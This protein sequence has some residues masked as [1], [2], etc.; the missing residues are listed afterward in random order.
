VFIDTAESLVGDHVPPTPQER[1][2]ELTVLAVKNCLAA[3]LTGVHNMGG[4]PSAISMF[5][6]LINEGRFPFRV[7]FNLSSRLSN[8]DELLAQGVQ[9]Y[10]DNRLI[11]RSV[12][13]FADGALGSRG[14]ALIEPYSD[15]PEST[16]L[17]I[18]PT[19][20]LADMAKRA[21]AAGFQ[22][23]THA[24][25]DNGNRIA[26]DAFEIALQAVPVEDHRLRV[27][28]AQ[29]LAPED[30]PRFKELGVLP[31]MQPTHCTSD[32]PWALDRLG[33]ER[34]KGAYAWRS[35]ID[36]GVIIPCGSDFPVEL[37]YPMHGIYSAV[38][39]RHQDGTPA[40]GYFPEQRM[41]REEAL[42]GFTIWAAY[43]GFT[44]DWLGS[45]EPGKRADLIVLDRDIMKVEVEK[46]P[47][48]KVLLTV[49]DGEIV[50]EAG[51]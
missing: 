51:N 44:E 8:L 36:T 17:I 31:S 37:I 35:L 3:G 2:K 11:V 39:R 49:F 12:K 22:V 20:E 33:A 1:L 4:G 7:Y 50:Y 5:K 21:L 18:T 32:F 43:A 13:C 27:E 16:G 9:Y 15:R 19:D 25:G 47:D 46:I 40:E 41:T 34:A 42:K 23:S 6:D 29:I 24:I 48:T 14:A 38:T 30:I 45:L 28:H 10:G 26:L